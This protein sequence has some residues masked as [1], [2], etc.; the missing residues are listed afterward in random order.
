MGIE[1]CIQCKSYAQEALGLC[2]DCLLKAGEDVTNYD[3]VLI[4][5]K[6][7]RE[8]EIRA[9]KFP[10]AE[11]DLLKLQALDRPPTPPKKPG[12]RPMPKSDGLETT[13]PG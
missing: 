2:G 12:L 8:L 3:P 6:R 7:L 5:R 4:E 11:I 13:R 1:V 9:G 10:T